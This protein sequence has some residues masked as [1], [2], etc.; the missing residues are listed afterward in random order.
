MAKIQT[1]SVMTSDRQKIVYD[2]YARSGRDLVIIAH[3][4]FNSKDSVL[5]KELGQA[6]SPRYDVILMDFRGHGK[7]RGLFYWTTKEHLDLLAV[8]QHVQ[9]DYRKIAV[10]GF[11][12]GAATTIIAAAR[13]QRIDSIVAVSAPTC[14]EKIEFH[15]WDLDIENDI[16]YNITGQGHIGKGVRPGPFWLK[17]ERPIDLVARVTC[18][19]LFIHGEADW[20][21][22]PWHSQALFDQARS[23]KDIAIL[24]NGPHAEYL[25]RK[26]KPET[27]KWIRTWLD[28]TL[29]GGERT[30]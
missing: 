5:L 19:I 17:K 24:K 18:P 9:N 16:F 2:H 13:T 6:L 29:D 20:L 3:G 26:N 30:S 28:K 11:S 14:F 10:I 23:L 15:F 4:F 27:I 7:S 8:L 25:I 22:R 12:L 21:I 1:K